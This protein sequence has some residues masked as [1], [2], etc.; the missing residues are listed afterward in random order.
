ME[1]ICDCS[2][3]KEHERFSRSRLLSPL[4][5][6][7]SLFVNRLAAAAGDGGGI[8]ENPAPRTA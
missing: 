6:L 5:N 7:R 1:N 8:F 2:G 4:K 3:S